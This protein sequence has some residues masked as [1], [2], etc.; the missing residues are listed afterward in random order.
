MSVDS[1]GIIRGEYGMITC[2]CAHAVEP[3]SICPYC[4]SHGPALWDANTHH[5]EPL[6]QPIMEDINT[7][8]VYPRA[9]WRYK[10]SLTTAIR[11]TFILA[12]IWGI[13]FSLLDI[14]HHW[15]KG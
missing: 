11:R 2:C 14:A 5:D 10:Y 12:M 6:M 4:P 13:P 3:Q 9:P 15:W 1:N 8:E 7:T